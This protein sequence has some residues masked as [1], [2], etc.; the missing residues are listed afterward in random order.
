MLFSLGL[1]AATSQRWRARIL[2]RPTGRARAW[3]ARLPRQVAQNIALRKAER[4]FS[5]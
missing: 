2:Q 1:S 5:Y 3:L 4:I